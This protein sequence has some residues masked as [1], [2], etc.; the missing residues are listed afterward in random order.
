MEAIKTAEFDYLENWHKRI[1][2]LLSQPDSEQSDAMRR[3][4]LA[5][6]HAIQNELDVRVAK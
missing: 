3:K 1:S 6:L 2:R 5:F 4:T